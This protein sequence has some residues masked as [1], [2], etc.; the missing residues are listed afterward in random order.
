M[1][2]QLAKETQQQ[3]DNQEPSVARKSLGWAAGKAW[4]AMKAP[5]DDTFFQWL[6]HGSTELANMLLHG[7]PAPV[8]SHYKAPDQPDPEPMAMNAAKEDAQAQPSEKASTP[9]G[10]AKSTVEPIAAP[11]V[12]SEQPIV[13]SHGPAQPAPQP[14]ALGILDRHMADLQNV[15]EMKQPEQE[16]SM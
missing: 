3:P 10:P 1:S 14:T 16:L 9:V 7:H 4:D 8:Y 12:T 5:F 15:P 6:S 2:K 11:Q 13:T